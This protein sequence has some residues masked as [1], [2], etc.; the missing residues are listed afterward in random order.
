MSSNSAISFTASHDSASKAVTAMVL[1]LLFGIATGTH[2]FIAV[3]IMTALLVAAYAWSPTGYSISNGD[4]VVARLIGDVR[5]PLYKIRAAKA[6]TEDDIRGC[7]RLFGSGGL[8]GYYGIFRTDR[9]GKCKWYVTNKSH[10]VVVAGEFG[11]AVLSPDNVEG[12]LGATRESAKIP[13]IHTPEMFVSPEAGS[14][15]RGWGWPVALPALVGAALVTA[16][17]FYSP[18][19]PSYTLTGDSLTIHDRFYP[20]TVRAGSVDWRNAR[21]VDFSTDS[22]W[23]PVARTNG[24]GTMHY[25]AGWFRTAGGKEVR[26]YRADSTRVVLL[27][28]KGTGSPVLLETQE[29]ERLVSDIQRKWG[30]R[31]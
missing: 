3:S 5:I 12:F 30:S 17:L 15:R 23:K 20:V 27:P 16:A 8:F 1:M 22:E 19:P 4:L 28:V 24:L 25:H 21:V 29:P 13:E 9:L 18:G 11:T 10:A 6:A 7:I 31:F 2:S 26:M 14:T